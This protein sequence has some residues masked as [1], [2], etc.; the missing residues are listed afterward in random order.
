MS[1]RFIQ[2]FAVALV[3]AVLAANAQAGEFEDQAEH[4]LSS[5]T[6]PDLGIEACSWLL[7]SGRLAEKEILFV[8]KLRGVAHA[9]KGDFDLAIRDL[10][11]AIALDPGDAEAYNARGA[12][13]RKGTSKNAFARSRWHC[14]CTPAS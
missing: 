8:Y 2:L 1:A 3:V 4:C 12:F 9:V 7:N 5:S 14:C 11:Q 10:G 13:Y 6:N